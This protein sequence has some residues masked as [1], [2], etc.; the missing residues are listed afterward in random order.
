MPRSPGKDLRASCAGKVA[1]CEIDSSEGTRGWGRVLAGAP[2]EKRLC[3]ASISLALAALEVSTDSIH[4]SVLGAWTSILMYRRPLMSI[5]RK[6]FTIVQGSECNA[7]APKY[8]PLPRSVADELVLAAV[9]APMMCSDLGAPWLPQVF[10]TDSSET[11]GAIVST[12]CDPALCRE[13]W[14][15]SDRKGGP[16]RILAKEEAMLRRLD[17]EWE[18]KGEGNQNTSGPKH[19]QHDWPDWG[20]KLSPP[21][22]RPVSLFLP[23]LCVGTSASEARAAFARAGGVAGPVLDFGGQRP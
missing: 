4:L 3:V 20:G 12:P 19:S 2:R 21:P 16:S 6:A 18:D 7:Q 14:L 9:L 1:G 23:L 22:A 15:A 11:G 8:I 5:F 10:A 17:P 13:I